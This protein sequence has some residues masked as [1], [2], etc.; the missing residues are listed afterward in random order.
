MMNLWQSYLDLYSSLPERCEQSWGLI[1][2][3]IDTISNIAFF[4][5]AYFIYQLFKRNKAKNPYMKILLTLVILM[6]IGST[7][8]H[9]FHNPFTL[10]ADQLPIYI[11]VVY[12]IYL[13]V[14]YVTK[15]KILLYLVPTLLVI[16]QFISL[17]NIPL[18]IFNVPIRH[19][20]NL[21]FIVILAVWS[22]RKL[23]NITFYIIPVLF[24][25]ALGIF[26]RAFDL[27]VCPINGVGT[28]FFWHICVAFTTYFAVRFLVKLSNNRF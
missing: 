13:F 22:Y 6:G 27:I 26:S 19:V 10:I 24:T 25:Y 3:P 15:N 21:I 8:Y 20:I 18:F 16:F 12:S 11:F 5:S 4:I 9:A 14:S 1:S 23:G 2:E 28:H 7:I 17:A